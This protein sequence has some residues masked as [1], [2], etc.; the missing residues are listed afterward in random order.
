MNL[1]PGGG[2]L[3]GDP[4]T[5]VGVR[6]EHLSPADDGPVAGTVT[7]LETLG[8]ETILWVDAGALE[9]SV[10]LAPGSPHRVGDPV[11]LRVHAE[12]RHTFDAVTGRRR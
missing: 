8:S 2:V 12:Q 10:R 5:V 11:R 7:R 6:P 1:A 9:L 3:G 4:D